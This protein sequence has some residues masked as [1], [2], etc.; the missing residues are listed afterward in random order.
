MARTLNFK[1]K[2]N[3]LKWLAYLW[4]NPRTRR[5]Y[6]G[7]PPHSRIRIRGRPHRVKH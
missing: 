6:A 1:S 3:Y 5:K 4:G 2:K 7:K